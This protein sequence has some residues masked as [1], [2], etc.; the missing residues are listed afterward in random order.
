ME[1]EGHKKRV[2]DLREIVRLRDVEGLSFKE[3]GKRFG[4]SAAN[5]SNRYGTKGWVLGRWNTDLP[6]CI[7]ILLKDLGINS[8][9]ELERAVDDGRMSKKYR[10]YSVRRYHMI[11][12]F[13]GRKVPEVK[14][15]NRCQHCGAKIREKRKDR[16]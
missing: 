14:T 2:A 16:E 6:T 8:R 3:I 11:L 5:A 12:E 4:I 7:R 13:L 10:N 15:G 9:K 1:L